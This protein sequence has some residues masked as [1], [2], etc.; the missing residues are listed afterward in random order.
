MT[1]PSGARPRRGRGRGQGLA[2]PVRDLHRPGDP[3]LEQRG[4]ALEIWSLRR[5][6]DR[7]LHPMHEPITRAGAAICRNISRTIRAA[8]CAACAGACAGCRLRAG[9]ARRS[10]SPTCGATP[11][12][13][14]VRRRG[15]ALVLAA[16]L[17]ADVGISRAFPAY[18]G[19][20][21]ALR[22]PDDAACPGAFRRTPRT[23]GPRQIGRSARSSPSSAGA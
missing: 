2:A 4:L 14:R 10:G 16:E 15:Q 11:R 13:N 19:L 23:S 5:P 17:P 3:G 20:G 12:A 21:D 9:A 6:T 1:P 22:R 18:A 7:A 8:C